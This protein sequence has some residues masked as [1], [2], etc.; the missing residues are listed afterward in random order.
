MGPLPTLLRS[1]NPP[2]KRVQPKQT[3]LG[4]TGIELMATRQTTFKTPHKRGPI[5]VSVAPSRVWNSSRCGS[6]YSRATRCRKCS[7][8]TSKQGNLRQQQNS[9]SANPYSRVHPLAS[10][11]L[12]ELPLAGERRRTA[13]GRA[14]GGRG[15][16]PLRAKQPT[17][18]PHR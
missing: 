11:S 9:F 17:A 1:R 16:H 7:R 13:S 12:L 6:P 3:Y 4:G 18:C 5:F 10:E 14:F 8:G 2:D 15:R